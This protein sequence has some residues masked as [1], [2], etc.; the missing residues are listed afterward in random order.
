M[1]GSSPKI[2]P[3]GPAYNSASVP[4]LGF[5]FEFS[6]N[7]PPSQHL[8]CHHLIL[9]KPPNPAD[10]AIVNSQARAGGSTW[11]KSSNPARHTREVRQKWTDAYAAPML[12]APEASVPPMYSTER[13]RSTS[14]P[15]ARTW[16]HDDRGDCHAGAA[17]N[18]FLVSR[19]RMKVLST[20][21]YATG[22]SSAR[23][24]VACTHDATS[25]L[26][27]TLQ[28]P[29][30]RHLLVTR[31]RTFGLGSMVSLRSSPSEARYREVSG[32]RRDLICNI[33]QVLQLLIESDLC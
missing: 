31:P 26:K 4:V 23:L 10:D 13:D 5:P 14:A 18:H 28:A 20:T 11:L 29:S 17:T 21:I 22:S 27:S 19:P 7:N 8:Q 15:A 33:F 16:I 6:L 30:T 32:R 25:H 3:G 12:K 1:T 9:S 24:H 2:C